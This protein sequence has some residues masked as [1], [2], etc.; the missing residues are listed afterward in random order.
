MGR[1]TA[2]GE[3]KCRIQEAE[4]CEGRGKEH[5]GKAAAGGG[6][7]GGSERQRQGVPFGREELAVRAFLERCLAP[8]GVPLRAENDAQ[9]SAGGERRESFFPFP[10]KRGC[11]SPPVYG[12][13]RK[14]QRT[15]PFGR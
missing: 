5:C 9:G 2:G 11:R 14:G 1:L 4:G 3:G 8:G 6:T 12:I 13:I 7:P 15:L 10:R